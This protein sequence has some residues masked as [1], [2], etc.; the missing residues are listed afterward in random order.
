MKRVLKP[1]RVVLALVCFVSVN[2]AFLMPVVAETLCL[3]S[4]PDFSWAA[5]M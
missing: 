1:L 3:E 5:K 4:S 2:A